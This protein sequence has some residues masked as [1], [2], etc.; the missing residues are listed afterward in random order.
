MNKK[1]PKLILRESSL[2]DVTK[3][4]SSGCFLELGAGTGQMTQFFLDKGYH[5]ACYDLGEESRN[6]IR[7][8]LISYSGKIDVVDD[9]KVLPTESFD[10]IFAFEVLEH[11]EDDIAA[12]QTWTRHLKPAGNILLSVPAH[13]KKFG[14]SDEIVGHIRRYEKKELYRLLLQSGYK[15]INIINYGFPLTELT[16]TISNLLLFFETS[17]ETWTMTERSIKSS[18]TRPLFITQC[19]N[20][21]SGKFILPFCLLQK[22]FYPLDWGDGYIAFAKKL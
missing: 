15:D 8:N 12:I 1:A 5:G 21:L 3:K 14:K 19:I 16:R 17:H 10:Y 6:A 13:Q 11:I 4:W 7:Q 9:I 22:L 18:Y 2:S 20:L